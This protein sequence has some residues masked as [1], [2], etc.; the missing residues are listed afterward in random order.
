MLMPCSPACILS[1]FATA[2]L[3]G[4]LHEAWQWNDDPEAAKLTDDASRSVEKITKGDSDSSLKADN[5]GNTAVESLGKATLK[6]RKRKNK[7]P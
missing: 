4:E 3:R 6:S 7:A 1:F 5:D 2:A